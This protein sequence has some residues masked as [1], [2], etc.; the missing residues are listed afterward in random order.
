MKT[1]QKQ[2]AATRQRIIDAGFALFAERGF[3]E[4]T[5]SL[6][7]DRANCSRVTFY[8]HFANKEQIALARI[9]QIQ[10]EIHWPFQKL[11]ERSEHTEESTLSFLL[12]VKRLWENF[13]VEF[14]AIER[15]MVNDPAVAEQWLEVI[16]ALSVECP[17][18]VDDPQLGFE[19]TAL[20]MSLDRNY[21]FLY[22]RG[23]NENEE[24]VLKGLVKQ[25]MTLLKELPPPLLPN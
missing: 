10:P 19:F 22:G 5:I 6:I 16:R 13:R 15:A 21:Y 24:G 9:L 12:D 8:Q 17:G 23:V 20:M 25:W 1:Q 14:A 11:F 18:A 2:T 4:T 3:D 7:S